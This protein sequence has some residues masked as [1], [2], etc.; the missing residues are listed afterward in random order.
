[1]KKNVL[2][3][4]NLSWLIVAA[5]L[6][7]TACDD[8]DDNGGGGDIVLDGMY[9]SGTATAGETLAI[10]AKQIIEPGSDFSIK[11]E[12]EGMMYQIH[13][14]VAGDLMFKEVLGGTQTDYGVSDVADS[15]QTAEAGEPFDYQRGKLVANGTT[16][17]TV[18]EAGL[19]YIITDKT[20]SNFWIMK[21]N[22][23]EISATGDKVSFVSGDATGATFEASAV[24]LRS[25]F[26]LRMN[27]AWKII[28]NDVPYT[29]TAVDGE[30]HVRMVTSY[31]GSITDLDPDGAD[32]EV[33]NGGK[34][35][36]FTFTWT[37]GSKGIAGV[38]GAAEQGADLPPLEFP[39]QMYMV[40]GSI[41]GW[42]WNTNGIEMIPV[43]SNS[44]LFWSVVWIESGATDPGIKFCEELDWG[45][46]FGVEGEAV[47]GVYAKGTNNVPDVDSSSYYIVVVNLEDETIEVN[48]ATVYGIGDAFGSWDAATHLF[49]IDDDNM[50]ITSPAFVADAELRMHVAASTLTTTDGNPVEW[51]QAEFIVLS[52]GGAIE[53]RGTGGDQDRI[54]V[55]TGET[56]S[57]NFKEG[58][59][60]F[61]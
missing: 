22:N 36:D 35:L 46:D 41:G 56:I 61:Q 51:W 38:V 24:E 14:L 34:L 10:D 27:T 57:L 13:Y 4:L 49:T 26:K 37:P 43:H 15:T 29:G 12:R 6:T 44:H 32:M 45:K 18:S 42:D 2:K 7:F 50:V 48:P 21:I 17:F 1:M 54:V 55:T 33:D 3:V 5:M 59:G 28:A 53:Y 8:D 58:T 40:G 11:E 31:G 25:K 23:F 19:Y 30:D 16:A 39:E 52:D 20:T 60:S 47:D 9:I